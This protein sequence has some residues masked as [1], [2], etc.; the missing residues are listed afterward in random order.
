M[1]RFKKSCKGPDEEQ[2]MDWATELWRRVRYL[3]QRAKSEQDLAEEMRLHMELR[4][5][6]QATGGANPHEAEAQARRRF[7][8]VSQLR[9]KS[10]EVWG[11]TLLDTLAQ[12]V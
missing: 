11:W 2:E 9:E 4:A 1:A 5:A 7:G 10:R 6:E 8:N 3:F 12:D